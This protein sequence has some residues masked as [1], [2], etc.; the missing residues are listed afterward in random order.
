[1]MGFNKT[2]DLLAFLNELPEI[3]RRADSERL[4]VMLPA[5]KKNYPELWADIEYC[6]QMESPS[7][8]IAFL[9]ERYPALIFLKKVPNVETTIQFLMKFIQERSDDDSNNHPHTGN[10]DVYATSQRKTRRSRRTAART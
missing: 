5:F 4:S 8:V 3:A 1:M 7:L 10:A 9:C 6:S 2:L